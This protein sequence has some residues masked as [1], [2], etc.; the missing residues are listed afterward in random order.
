M[1]L[2]VVQTEARGPTTTKDTDAD[3]G[4]LRPFTV[5]VLLTKELE[6]GWVCKL[7]NREGETSL[8]PQLFSPHSSQA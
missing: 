6:R 4:P 1:R 7:I 8:G 3:S 2:R 5:D